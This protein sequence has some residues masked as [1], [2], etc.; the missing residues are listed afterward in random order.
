M[1]LDFMILGAAKAGTSSM[2]H[3]VSGHPDVCMSDPR[4]SKFFSKHYHRGPAYLFERFFP[5]WS[6]QTFLCE[7]DTANLYVPYVAERIH[8]LFPDVKLVA[9]LRDPVDRAFSDWWMHYTVGKESL[10]FEG[11]V[12]RALEQLKGG[13]LFER[14]DAQAIWEEHLA[15]MEKGRMTWRRY[16]DAGYYAPQIREYWRV[17]GRERLLIL[18]A[19]DFRRDPECQLRRLWDFLGLDGVAVDGDPSLNESWSVRGAA[20]LRHVQRRGIVRMVPEPVRRWV[21]SKIREGRKPVLDPKLASFLSEHY[22]GWNEDLFSL[23][24]SRRSWKGT[25]TPPHPARLG[26]GSPESQP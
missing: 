12:E 7:A 24:G 22:R 20:I 8:R 14:P 6:G 21:R 9:L 10:P 11:A 3:I 16:L 18:F 23:L 4:E 26:D 2:S 17:F 5:H 19:E 25:T 13:S 1:K 15:A